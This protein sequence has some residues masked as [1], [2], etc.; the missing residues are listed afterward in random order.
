MRFAA[1]PQKRPSGQKK[2]TNEPI[3]REQ[4]V[5]IAEIN[6]QVCGFLVA[7]ITGDEAEILNTAVDPAYRRKGIG[8]LL[9]NSAI[10]AAQAHN[11]KSIYLEV[12]ESNRAA[13][14]FYGQH[15]FTKTAE[16]RGYYSSPTENAIV[17]KK[18][19]ALN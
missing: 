8:T 14:S 6:A 16:R 3:P 9:L 19:T 13:I 7:R 17:M 18:L 4:I 11:A 15:G 1:N 2:A 12:R 5:L 10:S